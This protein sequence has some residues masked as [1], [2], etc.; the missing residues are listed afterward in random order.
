M[1]LIMTVI[2]MIIFII[3]NNNSRNNVQHGILIWKCEKRRQLIVF[4]RR[5]GN[6]PACAYK[7][8]FGRGNHRQPQ[9]PTR[10]QQAS[11]ASNPRHSK[12]TGHYSVQ[13]TIMRPSV[14]IT[15]LVLVLAA[16][17]NAKKKGKLTK[18]VARH[19]L[20]LAS[21]SLPDDDSLCLFS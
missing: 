4:F 3:H 21:E 6:P 14:M 8:R 15:L 18:E 11:A 1:I 20:G 2:I 10:K 7:R 12:E 19:L 9:F 5:T 13:I 16:Q 17:C